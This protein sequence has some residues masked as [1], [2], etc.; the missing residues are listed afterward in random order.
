[1]LEFINIHRIKNFLIAIVAIILGVTIFLGFQTQTNSFSLEFQ[2]KQAISMNAAMM[3]N[4]PTVLEFYS[5]WCT[6]CKA[7]SSNLA[8]FKEEY[9]KTINFVMLNVD[10]NKWLPDILHYQ[11]NG[12]PYFVFMDYQNNIVAQTIGEQPFDVMKANLEAL[13]KN[14]KLP[15][16]YI[17]GKNSN[18]SATIQTSSDSPLSHGYKPS[19][20]SLK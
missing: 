16:T 8:K 1:M 15:Y 17:T 20:Q 10:N 6:S 13:D 5:T 11:I 2:A 14:K 12:I 19:N 7:M 18:F 3:N 4:K 9:S